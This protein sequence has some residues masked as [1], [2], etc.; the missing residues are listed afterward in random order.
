[1]NFKNFYKEYEKL[2]AQA[3]VLNKK[4]ATLQLIVSMRIKKNA[5]K[6]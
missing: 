1:M 5:K 4:S 6:M 2:K 3:Q